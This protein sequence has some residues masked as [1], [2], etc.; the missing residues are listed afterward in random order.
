MSLPRF[1][2]TKPVPVNLLMAAVL[3]AGAFAALTLQREFFPEADPDSAR[4]TLTYP[5]AA[6]DEIETSLA[7]KVEDAVIN[8][9]E[10]VKEITTTLGEGGGGIVVQF[11]EGIRNVDKAVDK[12]ERAVENLTDL[13]EDAERIRVVEFEPRLPVIMVTLTAERND[14]AAEHTLKEALR[15]I[16]DDLRTLP[17]MGEMTLSGVRQYEVRVDVRPEALLKHNLSVPAIADTIRNWMRDVPGGAIRADVGNLSVRTRGVEERSELIRQIILRSDSDGRVLRVGDVATVREDFVDD[18]ILTRFNGEPSMSLTVYKVGRQDAV[19]MAETV[20]AYVQGRRGEPIDVTPAASFLAPHRE[21]AWELGRSRLD[22]LPGDIATHTDLARF[23]EGRLDLLSK[24]AFYGAI[25]VFATLLT[26]L[27]WRIALWVGVGLTTAIAGTLVLM[28]VANVSLNLLTMFG[29]IVVLGLLVDDAIVVAENVQARHDRGEPALVAAIKGTEQVFWPVVATILTSI[30]AFMPLMFIEGRIGTLMGALPM[31]VACALTM[32]LI[33]SVLILP[34]HMGHT[35]AKRDRA[36]AAPARRGLRSL[37][38]LPHRYEQFRDRIILRRIVPAFGRFVRVSLTYRYISTAAALAILTISIG[39]AVGGRVGYTFLGSTDSE[40]IIVDVRMPIGTSISRTNTIVERIEHAARQQPET[41]YISSIVGQR[42][43]I[44]SGTTAAAATHIAQMFIELEP[45]EQ[46]DRESGEVIEAIRH[47]IGNVDDVERLS[48]S[49]ITG[50]PGGPDITIRVRGDHESSEAAMLVAVADIKRALAQFDDVYDIVDDNTL[51]QRESQVVVNASGAAL[52]LTNAEVGRQV[53]SA[54]FG[55]DAHTFA[56]KREDIDVRVRLDESVRNDLLALKDMWIVAPASGAAGG[57]AGG[58][59]A[60]P[61]TEIADIDDS[62]SYTT[63][64]RIDRKRTITITA[65][66]AP[67]ASPETIVDDLELDELRKKHH[68]VDITLGGRQQQQM[69]A[70]A[71]LPIGAAAAIVMIYVILAWL[72]SSYVQPLAVMTA[73]P[74]GVIGVIWG[75]MLLGYDLTFLS[76]IGFVALS[77]II[78]NDSL[79]LVQFYNAMRSSGMT[80]RDALVEASMQRFRPIFLTTVTTVL[81]LTPLML[82]QS[83]QARFLIPMAIAIAFGLL[84]ATM[85]ILLVLPCIIVIMDD[86]NAAAHYLWHGRPRPPEPTTRSAPH[87][88]RDPRDPY[89]TSPLDRLPD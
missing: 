85:V 6:P 58:P 41:R 73:I 68:S 40:T 54:L 15:R 56:A 84:A 55:I 49:E 29:L 13:P 39:M 38:T 44:D 75:H 88:P 64:R 16:E 26:F 76:L 57:P 46:R 74:F 35:L 78:V 72:F 32:S 9:V 24:N 34:S 65:D 25:L 27:N 51:G 18:Q 36:A 63:I 83:F 28:S 66:T 60:V 48:F 82:E 33:E 59:R 71:S 1:G 53:R 47:A 22:R 86:I 52:N 12:V 42:G 81:G 14:T 10:E 3:I 43:D 62:E 11:Q 80:V 31:V 17:N 8:E 77:G 2:V 69:E 7:I 4:V 89:E 50:G 70:F 20:R 45:V 19:R 30:V 87:S 79:I 21:Q 67:D 23:I 5:G 37:T 61:L